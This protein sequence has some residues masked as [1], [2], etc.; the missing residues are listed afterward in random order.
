MIRVDRNSDEFVSFDFEGETMS[1]QKGDSIAAALIAAGH[2]IFRTT[3]ISDTTR[4]PLCMMGVCFECLVEIDGL[5]N[6]QACMRNVEEGMQVKIQRGAANIGMGL[7]I[8]NID[9]AG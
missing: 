4:G 3:P 6:Q 2:K 9:E 1:A 8:N 7:P 5:G